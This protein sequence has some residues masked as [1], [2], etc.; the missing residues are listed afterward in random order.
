VILVGKSDVFLVDREKWRAT[1]I[2]DNQTLVL[3]VI[4]AGS[5][6]RS[7]LS[8]AASIAALAI[9]GFFLTPMLGP[10]WGPIAT[11]ALAI[12]ANLLINAL[13]P[14]EQAKKEKKDTYSIQ[15]FKNVANPNG[16]V[17]FV[18]GQ[19]RWA[20]HYAASS[21]TESIGDDRYI[22]AMFV[23][24]YGPMDLSDIRIGDTPI[25]KYKN[26]EIEIFEGESGDATSTLYS[27]QVV[28]ESLSI[29][30]TKKDGPQY[31]FTKIDGTEFSWDIT[32]SGG[33]YAMTMGSKPKQVPVTIR[34]KVAFR[35]AGSTS[36]YDWVEEDY[37]IT[38]KNTQPFTRTFRKVFDV[39][40][41]YEVRF[42][43]TNPD[44]D[45]LDPNAL[46]A[47]FSSRTDLTAMRTFRP[48]Y[49]LNF[50]RK[51]ALIVVRIKASNQLNGMLDNLN[52]MCYARIPDWTGSA[53]VVGNTKNPASAFRFIA[54][55]ALCNAYPIPEAD[56]LAIEEWHSWCASKGLEY[57]KVIQDDGP[58][59][60]DRLKEAAAAGRATPYDLGSKWSVTIDRIMTLVSGHITERNSSGFEW[61]RNYKRLPDAFRVHFVDQTS[62]YEQMERVVPLPHW[63]GG[64][65]TIVQDLQLE[66]ITDPA[67]VYREARRRGY[68]LM[69]RPDTYTVTQDFEHLAVTRGDLVR[70]QHSS[71]MRAT[72][73]GRIS[74]IKRVGNS[75]WLLLD[76]EV[77]FEVGKSYNIRIRDREGKSRLVNVVNTGGTTKAVLLDSAPGFLT[78]LL[79]ATTG[80]FIPSQ[81]FSFEDGV[82][83]WLGANATLASEGGAL[84]MTPSTSDP[85]I[86]YVGLNIP[87]K[88]YNTI[89]V[90]TRA[91]TTGSWEGAVYYTTSDHGFSTSYR[92]V[93][94]A[95]TQ[96]LSWNVL[97]FDMTSLTSGGSDW[98][99]STIHD[100]SLELFAST[101]VV[102]FDWIALGYSE[103][104]ISDSQRMLF[105]FGEAGQESL[106]CIVTGVEMQDN[107]CAK[108]SMIDHAPEIET[109]TDA[110]VAPPWSGRVG[111]ETGASTV[112]PGV[113]VISYIQ[114]GEIADAATGEVRYDQVIVGLAPGIGVTA[115]V[116]YEVYHKL[117][118]SGTW[119]GPVVALAGNNAAT[120]TGVYQEFD[121]IDVRARAKGS[122]GLYSGYTATAT[123]TVQGEETSKVGGLEPT[124]TATFA[125]QSYQI[126]GESVSL[127]DILSGRQGG[128]KVIKQASGV[129]AT[130]AAPVIA[131]D[132]SSG[133]LRLLRE[134]STV[135]YIR[136]NGPESAPASPL[137]LPT[138]WSLTNAFGIT[139]TVV[140]HSVEDGI[141]CFDI[142]VSGTT[143]SN[144][145]Q[146]SLI[147]F[148]LSTVIASD[149]S[150]TPWTNSAFFKVVSGS[151]PAGAAFAPRIYYRTSGGAYILSQLGEDIL[152][153]RNLT[154][155]FVSGSTPST[156]PAAAY[157]QPSI[158]IRTIPSGTALNFTYRVGRPQLEKMPFMTSPVY[159]N[160]SAVT[161]VADYYTFT[162]RFNS[163]IRAGGPNAIALRGTIKRSVGLQRV[164]GDD[165]SY[166]LFQHSTN[167]QLRFGGASSNIAAS[168]SVI[169]GDVGICLGWDSSGR[170]ATTNGAVPTTDAVALT[171]DLSHIFLGS[172]FGDVAGTRHEWDE[173]QVWMAKP[174]TL[175]ARKQAHAWSAE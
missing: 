18:F 127:G 170:I 81:V 113:P 1:R 174:T 68:E 97:E 76:E 2:K 63:T 166:F 51:L 25:S 28:E 36:E 135:N 65:P 57:N 173:L 149:V 56:M 108:V 83:G 24:G 172:K 110:E 73:A 109:L 142:R 99:N 64:E 147:N 140:A 158:G 169:P 69:Y 152:N 93:I 133:S 171:N 41:Q 53:W 11:A 50:D 77:T 157:I 74:E 39:R 118:S 151:L 137:G 167:P 146:Q 124:V 164:L 22:T 61:E 131:L 66:G 7:I 5:G 52:V 91:R 82:S 126:N 12:G 47:Q 84:V 79:E 45:E 21:W 20:P 115:P 121:S 42:I 102:E 160:G 161:R 23:C 154:R 37:L 138:N 14:V 145:S 168:G 98:I 96:P 175:D 16:S 31:R 30:L 3:R 60:L 71:M 55:S 101:N 9:G 40:G 159:T 48:E 95:P 105:V 122:N 148:E 34:F 153:Y 103:D 128:S 162:D 114:S 58:S 139:Q 62:D 59:V 35:P 134:G 72:C 38:A 92:K 10:V 89:R 90:K 100:I 32:C 33:L 136:Y 117:S 104:A 4:P 8:L 88:K 132:Y 43:R 94:S 125:D 111:E 78:K 141:D 156:S 165:T 44:Y 27:R 143:T 6:L 155:I 123:H 144:V 116:S 87:G 26:V 70:M 54:T 130:I 112:A 46:G 106:E 120:L 49:P 107:L 80:E 13:I 119:V 75:V 85:A 86:Y 129:W 17:P 29:N 15:G 150:G 67:K 163:F 19:V